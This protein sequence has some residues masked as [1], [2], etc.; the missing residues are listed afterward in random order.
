MCLR[1][2]QLE[3]LA[4]VHANDRHARLQQLRT[5]VH[6]MNRMA[7]PQAHPHNAL[8]SLVHNNIIIC[9]MLMLR[10]YNCTG[11]YIVKYRQSIAFCN[12]YIGAIFWLFWERKATKHLRK[13]H[14]SPFVIVLNITLCS[15]DIN[16]NAVHTTASRLTLSWCVC[17]GLRGLLARCR[18]P[19]ALG[20][21]CDGHC[22]IM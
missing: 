16:I 4:A 20:G 17:S 6:R 21:W 1:T 12:I 11:M 13:S 9:I 18:N 22:H 5:G 2:K 8:H 7:L 3:R 15:F 10:L 19:Q 14:K